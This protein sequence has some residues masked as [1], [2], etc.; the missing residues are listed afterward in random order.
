MLFER[1]SELIK[2]TEWK[3][4]HAALMAISQSGEGCQ[5]QMARQLEQ[6]VGMIVQVVGD[7]AEIIAV[8]DCQKCKF[9]TI[10]LPCYILA[11]LRRSAPARPV[12][13]DQHRRP[14]VDRLWTR[15]T[16]ELH[17]QKMSPLPTDETIH[18]CTASCRRARP[19]QHMKPCKHVLRA[20]GELALPK[21]ETI[22]SM[23]M[24]L[25]MMH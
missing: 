7:D 8:R 17:D 6:I 16:G 18:P 1:I 11:A 24:H 19:Y 3:H 5:S 4:R 25:D 15:A 2:S 10:T 14:D 23:T 12:G 21:H 13:G 22:K 20:T 9:V